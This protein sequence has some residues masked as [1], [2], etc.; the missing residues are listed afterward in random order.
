MV[1]VGKIWW[2]V[3]KIGKIALKKNSIRNW[4]N[5]KLW[6]QKIGLKKLMK[7]VE[8]GIILRLLRINKQ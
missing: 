3:V 6:A 8:I 1:K 5:S 2:K 4:G 7:F